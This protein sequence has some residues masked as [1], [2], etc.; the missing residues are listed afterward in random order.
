MAKRPTR[1]ITIAVKGHDRVVRLF[2]RMRNMPRN[3][4]TV[5]R[6]T[7]DKIVESAREKVPVDT[8]LLYSTI[9]R[10]NTPS[11]CV[12]SAGEPNP[13]PPPTD[14]IPRRKKPVSLSPNT[15]APYALE[16]HESFEQPR[17]KYLEAAFIE[18]GADLRA[19]Y[20]PNAAKRT[21]RGDLRPQ[22][23]E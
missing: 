12:V 19:K 20:I 3:M 1:Q 23:E 18:E 17:R 4:V 5:T 15:A 13:N 9:Q 8:G 14:S 21:M 6:Q 2:D 22:K 10:R 7:G 11:G 16:Q